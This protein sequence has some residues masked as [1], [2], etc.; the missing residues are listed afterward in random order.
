[1]DALS[2]QGFSYAYPGA[3]APVLR[4]VDWRVP[5]GAFVILVGATGSGKTTLLRCAKPE[6]AVAG[7]RSGEVRA[8]GRSLYGE[9]AND[10]AEDAEDVEDA[11]AAPA[12][13]AAREAP[14]S[15]LIGYVAQNPET[16]IVCDTV[17]HELAFGL[18]NAGTPPALM[19]R[20]VAEV[21]HFFGIEPWFG[22]ETAKLSGGQ[23]QLLNL[24]SALALRPR[25]LLL[26]EPT[27]QL[28]PV[29]AKN[30]LH[31]LFR[32]NRE[33]GITVVMATH[34]PESAAAYATA[35][36]RLE[37]GRIAPARL[38]EF[39]PQSASG[40][41]DMACRGETLA[42]EDATGTTATPARGGEEAVA[43]VPASS[44]R[45]PAA[46]V[47]SSSPA[48]EL[49]EVSFR[50]ERD[51]PW[52]LAGA[53]LRV[54]P[55]TVHAIVGGNG[56]GKSTALRL[57]AG[58]LKPERGRVH[59][60]LRDAQALVPQNPRALFACDTVREELMEWARPARYGEDDAR[61]M[62]VRFGL[63]GLLGRHPSDLSGG[64]QQLLA[65]AKVLLTRPHLLLL[66]EP[67][68]GLDAA[69]KLEVARSLREEQAKGTTVVMVSHDL[70]FVSCVA[71]EV[72]MLFDGEDACTE[73]AAA[74][75]E[76]NLF[77]RPE[78]DTF[79]RLWAQEGA[80]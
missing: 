33:C 10:A 29:A 11:A 19:R 69:S 15:Q 64:Q 4:A 16:Q 8:F 80:R 79:M 50:Y 36:V 60:S 12:A 76:G 70:S 37:E 9:G 41:G 61:A 65:E 56:C 7:E 73:P 28:D 45:A 14:A 6:L 5:A 42:A 75:F 59:N 2:F 55:A 46:V 47:R 22:R 34:A 38:E 78:P 71:D 25:V 21:A 44:P 24:A 62:A 51:L 35:A 18:E 1:M 67:A 52:V 43:H 63:D 74:F 40:G 31:A 48:L 13:D 17:W 23:K 39:L 27:G 77:F 30:F 66:D 58:V 54:A 68:K 72:T 32:V 53:C 3:D 49:R 26:D 57:V 20:R